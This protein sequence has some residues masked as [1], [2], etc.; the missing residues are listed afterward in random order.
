MDA[1]IL[2][3]LIGHS[4]AKCS[5]QAIEAT[6]DP[7]TVAVRLTANS[8]AR[9]LLI[10]LIEAELIVELLLLHTVWSRCQPSMNL[11]QAGAAGAGCTSSLG[12]LQHHKG[13][14]QTS[15]S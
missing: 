1:H 13:P 2:I 15:L 4:G 8:R 14:L 6:L 3:Y 12:S 7:H 9:M 10:A 5:L 11:L